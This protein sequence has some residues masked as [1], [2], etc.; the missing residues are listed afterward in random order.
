MDFSDVTKNIFFLFEKS[1]N[2]GKI[3]L[4]QSK[5]LNASLLFQNGK[6]ETIL[7]FFLFQNSH[8]IFSVSI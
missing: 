2:V 5:V 7:G 3:N 1:N 4:F 8:M 6:A